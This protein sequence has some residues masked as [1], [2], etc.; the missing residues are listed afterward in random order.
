MLQIDNQKIQEFGLMT[1]CNS[2]YKLCFTPTNISSTEQINFF[3]TRSNNY[4]CTVTATPHLK[5]NAEEKER[6]VKAA[7]RKKET[8]QISFSPTR[9]GSVVVGVVAGGTIIGFGPTAVSKL[10]FNIDLSFVITTQNNLSDGPATVIPNPRVPTHLGPGWPNWGNQLKPK[11][12][13]K[14]SIQGSLCRARSFIPVLL[15]HFRKFEKDLFH[16]VT[17]S[18]V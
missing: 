6:K 9:A 16:N 11:A 14:Q 13:N 15:N 8:K 17:I 2:F 5:Q 12:W 10:D 1:L 7:T 18:V 3:F 4:S